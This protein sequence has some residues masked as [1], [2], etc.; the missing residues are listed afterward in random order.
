M[1]EPN[2]GGG[3]EDVI[4]SIRR[5]VAQRAHPEGDVPARLV[6]TQS[7]RID[8]GTS[9]RQD[10]SPRAGDG[11]GGLSRTLD[12]IE[13]ALDGSSRDWNGQ[14]PGDPEGEPDFDDWEP[15]DDSA[16]LRPRGDAASSEAGEVIELA[17]D[18]VTEDAP[19]PP[20]VDVA[21]ADLEALLDE[22][23]LRALVAEVLREELKGPLG[24]RITRNVRKLVRREIAQALSTL[25]LD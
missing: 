14:E 11:L 9:P 18:E 3:I 2:P 8:T 25:D 23:E 17:A 20:P 5:L 15:A 13:A 16:K 6:L 19:A 10:G 22:R 12:E 21:A 7:L 4:T 1:M 24:E